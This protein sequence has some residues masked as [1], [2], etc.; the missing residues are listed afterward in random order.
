[1]RGVIPLSWNL[2]HAGPMA[3]SVLDVALLLEAIAGYDAEDPY[4]IDM[5]V[6][7]YTAHIQEGV[8]GWRVALAED[9]FYSRTDAEVQAAVQGAADVFVELGA[10]V[11]AAP[12]PGARQAARANSLMTPSDGAAYHQERMEN[13][14]EDYGEDVL[15]RLRTGA[16]YTSSQYIQA[17][18]TQTLLR[19]QFE[20]FFQNYD[21]LLTPATAVAAPPIEG[22]DAVEQA[23]LLTRYTAAFN[24]TGLP[25][26]SVPC[27]FTKAGLPIG[28]QMVARP[29][30][31]SRLLRA[32]HAYESATEWHRRSPVI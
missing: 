26:I 5:E 3:R 1:M 9:E 25:A 18:R 7:D 20:T 4:S 16:A 8:R 30:G 6:D 13:H 32:A 27:G 22:P 31:E 23:R 14:P 2:D 15:R 12:F 10:H 17:R 11:E 21:I 19:R 28:L 24:L 29:W